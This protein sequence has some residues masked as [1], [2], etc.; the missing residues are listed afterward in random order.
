MKSSFKN[1]S[2]TLEQSVAKINHKTARAGAARAS[3][4]VFRSSF[5]AGFA[6]AISRPMTI[7]WWT[8][9]FGALMAS[10]G[11][12]AAGL[13]AFASCWSILPGCFLWAFFLAV[14][15]HWGRSIVTEG[16]TRWISL[17]ARVF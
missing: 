17:V 7:V 5:F 14:S 4:R 10:Q 3:G 16:M 15:P 12:A 9:V 6:L 2:R 1:G 13:F 8:G 11:K